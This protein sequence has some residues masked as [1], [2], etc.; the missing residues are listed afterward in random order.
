M[1]LLD[2]YNTHH[3]AHELPPVRG[4]EQPQEI[5]G[6]EY[7]HTGGVQAEEGD[8]VL[9]PGSAS[10]ITLTG[11]PGGENREICGEFDRTRRT[12]PR[13]CTAP[14]WRG[15][16]AQNYLHRYKSLSREKLKNEKI[17][18]SMC[19]VNFCHFQDFVTD[20]LWQTEIRN[21]FNLIRQ[22]TSGCPLKPGTQKQKTD[23]ICPP[24]DSCRAL[25]WHR[26]LNKG[27]PADWFTDQLRSK[28]AI[29]QPQE[30]RRAS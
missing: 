2:P 17:T 16:L 18:P 15:L 3:T 13:G 23:W 30:W 10:H 11:A 28:S 9:R 12:A 8:F 6:C 20:M 1:L 14:E 29:L 27:N 4:G 25:T 21:H 7:H 26:C 19:I 22:S 5:L 24:I